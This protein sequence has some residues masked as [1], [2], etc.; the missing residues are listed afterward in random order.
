MWKVFVNKFIDK[1]YSKLVGYSFKKLSFNVR[2][3]TSG[4]VADHE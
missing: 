3:T 4:K 2:F 1:D